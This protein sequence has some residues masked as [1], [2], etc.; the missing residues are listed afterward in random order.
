MIKSKSPQLILSFGEYIL[1]TPEEITED[2]YY[3][4]LKAYD[5]LNYSVFVIAA[6]NDGLNNSVP[7]PFDQPKYEWEL[8]GQR[9]PS[10][11]KGQYVYPANYILK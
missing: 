6:G 11:K 5:N 7:A 3:L 9:G 2:V 4:A 8:Y 1:Q 10:F